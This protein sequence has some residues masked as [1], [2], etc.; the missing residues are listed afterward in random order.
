MFHR[1]SR[2]RAEQLE[3]RA[4]FAITFAGPT[5]YAVD[6]AP[7][8]DPAVADFNG[9]GKP[10]LATAHTGQDENTLSV[11]L[12]GGGGNFPAHTE[13]ATGLR[14]YQVISAD[15]NNDGKNDL[16]NTNRVAGTFNTFLGNGD[17]TFGAATPTTFGATTPVGTGAGAAIAKA[18]LNGDAF[19]D[20]VISEGFTDEIVTFLGNGDG[21]FTQKDRITD[22]TF[23]QPGNIAV[24]DITGDGNADVVTH[25]GN[26]SFLIVYTTDGS[27]NL[28]AAEPLVL[29]NGSGNVADIG[30]AIA[31]FNN[32]TKLDVAGMFIPLASGPAYVAVFLG[33]GDGTF[34]ASRELTSNVGLAS[35]INAADFDGDG[36]L[37]VAVNGLLNGLAVYKGNGDGTFVATPEFDRP[38]QATEA[39]SAADLDGDGDTDLAVLA[40]N[41][42]FPSSH[43]VAVFLNGN[44]STPTPTPTPTGTPAAIPTVRATLPPAVVAGAKVKGAKVSVLVT[45]NGTAALNGPVTVSLFASA[46]DALDGADAAVAAP[47]TKRLKIAPGASKT[48]KLKVTTLPTVADGAYRLVAQTTADAGVTVGADASDTTVNIAAPFVDLSGSFPTSP[49]S[50]PVRAGRTAS[51]PLT[52]SNA[53]NIPVTGTI[54]VVFSAGLDQDPG[55]GDVVLPAGTLRLK[56]KAASAKVFRVKVTVPDTLAAGPYFLSAAIDSGEVLTEPNEGDNAFTSTAAVLTVSA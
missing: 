19:P 54:G 18:D 50:R 32:D 42:N 1:R 17:G 52:I 14:P 47:V 31:D 44:S 15:V 27:G 16:V 33:N 29:D 6:G 45:N 43:G 24:G 55:D 3:S 35:G 46:D 49:P 5:D 8:T 26:N 23:G 7:L 40:F 12:N 34:Q 56:L 39:A 25:A 11:L 53:G 41:S 22:V 30:L 20:L 38:N 10:D 37:D 4:Y 21:M 36:T 48:V 13:I 51:I 9:D 2:A 28:T